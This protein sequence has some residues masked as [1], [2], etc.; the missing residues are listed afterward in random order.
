MVVDVTLRVPGTEKDNFHHRP[1]FFAMTR[2]NISI[3]G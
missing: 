1:L 2:S 3:L